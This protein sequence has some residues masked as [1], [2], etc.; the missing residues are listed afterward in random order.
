MMFF[1]NGFAKPIDLLGCFADAAA[2]DPTYQAQVAI[3]KATLQT[4]PEA[5]AAVMP[6]ATLS[7]A[8]A[9][10]YQMMGQLGKG[11]FLTNSYGIQ[12]NQTIFNYTQFKQITQ[13]RYSV[14]AAFATLLAQEQE[15]ITRTT[16][17]YFDVLQAH[18]LMEFT[19]QQHHYL[20]SQLDA[21]KTLFKHNDA[22]ITDLEQAQGAYDLIN[23]DLYAAKIRLYDA[24]QNLS[25]I[26]GIVYKEFTYLNSSFPLTT[27]NPNKLETWVDLANNQNWNLRAS[28]L[29]IVV[30]Q[31]ALKAT[32]GNFL[33]SLSGTAGFTRANVPSLLL[34]DSVPNNTN[35]VGLN[36]NWSFLQGGL[37]VAQVK[38]AIANVQQSE[39]NMRQQYLKTMADTRKA[40]NNITV[41]V[42]R[43]RSV[44]ASLIA[45]TQAINHA[46]EA[47][48]A[49]EL[50]ITEILQIQYQLY[51]A[52][53]L[54]TDYV[55]TYIVNFVL[56]KQ[57]AGILDVGSL[58]QLNNW[59]DHKKFKRN[60]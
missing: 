14:R 13:A 54:Y 38:A 42:P 36:A 60:H 18:D 31:E 6:Q 11:T 53:T 34:I 58:V 26:T 3:Y 4:L 10:E 1:A 20:L 24:I 15:L 7:S 47:Y 9:R 32:K 52:Q 23:A 51:R 59:L 39:A 43:V 50:T 17:G 8:I 40:Y 49:G 57:A 28:R 19:E 27:P 12:A 25:Q 35:M 45:N 44:R 16:K 33:P 29:N 2:N 5:A 37:T 55:Y 48:K 41:G 22:T 21:T 46:E 56:L 30:A